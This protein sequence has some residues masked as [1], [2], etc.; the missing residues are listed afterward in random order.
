LDRDGTIIEEAGYLK[1]IKDIKLIKGS[2]QAIK[3]LNDA[4]ILTIVIT[5]QS[6]VARGYYDENCVHL[7]HER[8]SQLL[9]QQGACLDA[10]YYCPHLKNGTVTEY[11]MDCNCRKPEI[12]MFL[13]AI[14]KFSIDLNKSFMIGD[15]SSDIK[16]GQRAGCKTI[17]VKTGYGEQTSECFKIPLNPPLR[18]GEIVGAGLAPP[19]QPDFI[20]YNLQD[21]IE[22]ILTSK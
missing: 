3:K 10:I 9:K 13:K 7:I 16:A 20:A 19:L 2:A 22:W 8:L 11:S 12:G 21:A 17:L 14:K 5:N 1:D 4:N 15:K 6:G 18:K